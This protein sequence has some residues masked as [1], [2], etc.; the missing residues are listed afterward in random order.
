M[1]GIL[2]LTRSTLSQT[3]IGLLRLFRAERRALSDAV[4]LDD[5]PHD[6]LEDMGIAP[7]TEANHRHSGQTGRIPQA[8]LW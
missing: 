2:T 6:R 7:R 4:K 5:L 1:E 3:L 8:P